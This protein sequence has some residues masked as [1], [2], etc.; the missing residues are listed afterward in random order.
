MTMRSPRAVVSSFVFVVSVPILGFA[1]PAAGPDVTEIALPGAPLD[2][3]SLDY[4]A[5]DRGRHRVWVPAGG[6][7]GV[8]VIDTETR[9]IHRIGGFPVAEVER[10][11]R[12]RIVGPSS[13]TVGSGF[14]YV[15]DR[16]DSSVCAVNA[17]SLKRGG[18]VTLSSMPDGLAYVASTR[19]VWVTAPRERAILVL[20]VSHPAQPR[21]AGRIALEGDPE[22]YAVDDAHGVFYTNYE[23]RDRTVRIAIPSRTVTATWEPACG[24]DGPRGLVLSA[25]GRFLMVACPDHLES[26][27]A[28]SDG[29]ILSTLPTGA[30]VDD[31]DYLPSRRAVY[32]AAA[33]DAVLT[34]AT[35]D[36]EGALHAAA[37]LTT[38]QGARNAVVTDDGEAYVACG[39]KG[40]ILIVRPAIEPAGAH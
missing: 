32:A 13:A 11:G 6:T 35:L 26:L 9:K 22:G 2:G 33:A 1:G 25:D 14:V 21:V 16:A 37:S 20:D 27:A 38:S 29:R 31:L 28:A 24:E 8:V 12:K 17:K 4:L 19:E 5:S 40:K 18:C 3:V 39:P 23:D 34:V 7:G 15:G 10:N 36:E 30:G